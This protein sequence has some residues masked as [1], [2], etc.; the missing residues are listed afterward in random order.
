VV[1]NR[2]LASATTVPHR[3]QLAI[4]VTLVIASASP[5][6]L[7]LTL[8]PYLRLRGACF[9]LFVIFFISFWEIKKLDDIKNEKLEAHFHELL[10]FSLLVT[11]IF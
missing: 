3:A 4:Q 8:V 9:Q 6:S 2:S 10:S 5:F 1:G 11:S 7:S